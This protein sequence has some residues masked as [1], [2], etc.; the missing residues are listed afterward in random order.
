MNDETKAYRLVMMKSEPN[1]KG[2]IV[3]TVDII[4]DYAS[5]DEARNEAF[6]RMDD[7]T[8][9]IVDWNINLTDLNNAQCRVGKTLYRFVVLP[10]NAEPDPTTNGCTL[11]ALASLMAALRRWKREK[12]DLWHSIV[13]LDM[14]QAW[15]K[16]RVALKVEL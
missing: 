8:D 11:H 16:A 2:V 6:E 1:D 3:D 15:D 13:D 12:P 5:K 10:T 9:N 14:M 7:L 4:G